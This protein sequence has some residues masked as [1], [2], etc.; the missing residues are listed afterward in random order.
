MKQSI[1]ERPILFSTP[2]VRAILDGRK[3]QTRRIM[4]PQPMFL[5]GRGK[6]VYKTEDYKKSWEDVP[7]TGEGSGYSDCPYGHPGDHLWVR[8]TWRK[9]NWPTGHQYEYRA[10]AKEDGTPEDGPWRPSIFMPREASRITL[11]IISIK[12]ERLNDISDEDAIAE[13]IDSFKPVPGDGDP[14]PRYRDYMAE[15]KF[16]KGKTVQ[17]YPFTSPK[18][19]F[20]SLWESINGTESLNANPW[21]WVINFRYHINPPS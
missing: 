7:G 12:V 2:M 11:G 17:K 21:V 9:N 4:K 10:T 13:G 14:T 8:E 18:D 20:L 3:T 19:S 15:R 6:R 16:L 1:N 5:T